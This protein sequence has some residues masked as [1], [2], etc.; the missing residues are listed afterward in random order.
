MVCADV[1]DSPNEGRWEG[2]GGDSTRGAPAG[3]VEWGV[4]APRR[5]H[6]D[7]TRAV[8]QY[9]CSLAAKLNRRRDQ[10]LNG[11][12]ESFRH[13][14]NGL[15]DAIGFPACPCLRQV[16]AELRPLAARISAERDR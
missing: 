14:Q 11:P 7:V 8:T 6:P 4:L 5:R 12:P 10:Q 9:V 15:S 1:A 16:R 3:T 13:C 2:Y